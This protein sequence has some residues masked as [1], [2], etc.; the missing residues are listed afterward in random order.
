MFGPGLL[1]SQG[2]SYEICL[3][4]A[5]ICLLFSIYLGSPHKKQRKLLNPIFTTPYIRNLNPTFYAVAYQLRDA[6][7][8]Q[9]GSLKAS[10]DM[11]PPL[12]RVGLE[13][14]GQAGMGHNFGSLQGGT[15][16]Y[17]KAL[18]ELM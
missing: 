16:G 8:R 18:K 9:I 7:K 14:I 1:T 13:L 2:K 12:A 4:S 10:I 15:D 17:I 6:M 5:V 3:T 11:V